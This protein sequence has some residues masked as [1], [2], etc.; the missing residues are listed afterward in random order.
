MT[1]RKY[2]IRLLPY[3]KHYVYIHFHPDHPDDPS[4]V[5]YVGKGT[6]DR[7]WSRRGTR[8][9][10]HWYQV[11]D[12]QNLGITPD[13]WVK[14]VRRKMTADQALRFEKQLIKF[15]LDKG[16]SLFNREGQ[17]SAQQRTYT[18]HFFDKN[19][20]KAKGGKQPKK[21]APVPPLK[22]CPNDPGRGL[23]ICDLCVGTGGRGDPRQSF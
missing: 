23:H 21:R 20:M 9:D 11:R 8:S 19:R 22:P 15:Y 10:D 7:A 3:P 16:A 4:Y 5:M 18:P 6:D 1:E 17:P 2:R 13:Q 12:W 14:I